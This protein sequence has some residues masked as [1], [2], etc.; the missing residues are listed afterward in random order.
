MITDELIRLAY[1]YGKCGNSWVRVV[2]NWA[3][4]DR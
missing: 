2:K 4:D 3:I 1:L